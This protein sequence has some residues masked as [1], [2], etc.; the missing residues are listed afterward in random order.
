M[1]WS[2][3]IGACKTHNKQVELDV[4]GEIIGH[5]QINVVETGV[6]KTGETGI[7]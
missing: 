4:F 5:V 3:D 6:R 1:D 2:N 7:E